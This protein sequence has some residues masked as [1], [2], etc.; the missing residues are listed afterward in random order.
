MLVNDGTGT[1]TDACEP[2]VGFPSGAI[3]LADRGSCNFTVK[4]ANAQAAGASAVIVANNVGGPPTLMGGSDPS[5]TIPSGMISLDDGNT[6][7]AGLPATGTVSPNPNVDPCSNGG[8]H[9]VDISSPASP[10]RAGCFADHGYIHDTQCVVYDGPDGDHQGREICFNSNATA[11]D[12]A[13]THALSIVDVTD[14]SNPVAL[15]RTLYPN[16]GYSH[17]GWLTPDSR[18]FLHG[19]ELDETTH[20]IGTTTR[21]FNVTDLDNP[22]LENTFEN[23][24]TSIDHNIYTE[25]NASYHSNYTSGLRVYDN[26]NLPE[27]T[28]RRFFD[29]YPEDD[30]ATFVGTWSNYPYFNQN[31]I[32]AVSSID[33]GLFVFRVRG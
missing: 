17:Q 3:A 15:S 6:I 26:R 27:L 23:E 32:V 29:V 10:E 5:I 1:T 28:E 24:T 14:K 16:P 9:M 30:S 4:V 25:G 19:D 7:K 18:Y 21:V 13:A 31:R 12:P 11:V 33:R 8:L 2:L 20:G 22:V